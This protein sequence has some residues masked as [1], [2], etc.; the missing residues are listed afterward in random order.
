[1]IDELF[2]IVSR[3]WAFVNREPWKWMWAYG[4]VIVLFAFIYCVW[5]SKGFYHSTAMHEPGLEDVKREI[6]TDLERA[7]LEGDVGKFYFKDATVQ[8]LGISPLS[9][10]MGRDEVSFWVYISCQGKSHGFSRWYHVRFQHSLDFEG[11]C[12]GGGSSIKDALVTFDLMRHPS[13]PFPEMDRAIENLGSMM[14]RLELPC[15]LENKINAYINASNGFPHSVPNLGSRMLYLSAV[16]ITTLGYGD[17][18][19]ITPGNRFLVGLES[20]I[21][22]LLIGFFLNSVAKQIARNQNEAS[23]NVDKKL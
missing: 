19:P 11:F 2:L 1:M 3:M 12:S 6:A 14:E 16:T 5:G 23:S 21:G 7:L 4:L 17:I 13:N 8:S 18:V 20:V 22:I 9:I 15:P 10:E